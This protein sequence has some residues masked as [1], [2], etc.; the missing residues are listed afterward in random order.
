[1]KLNFNIYFENGAVVAIQSIMQKPC[2]LVVIGEIVNSVIFKGQTISIQAGG[3]IPLYD[4]IK[5]IEINHKEV[6][7]A[8]SAQLIGICLKNT[9]KEELLEYLGKN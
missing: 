2:G 1:M 3:K 7:T 4:E 6:T 9:S 8:I 5:R